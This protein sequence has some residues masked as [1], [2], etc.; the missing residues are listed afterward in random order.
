MLVAGT[1]RLEIRLDRPAREAAPC[2]GRRGRTALIWA[3]LNG[4]DFPKKAG[5]FFT[6]GCLAGQ[7]HMTCWPRCRRLLKALTFVD[8][9][10]PLAGLS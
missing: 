2:S 5:N 10:V 9:D 7:G 8:F 4:G 6:S 3:G 1:R